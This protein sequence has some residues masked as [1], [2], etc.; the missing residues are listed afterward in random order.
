MTL[1]L[2]GGETRTVQVTAENYDVVQMVQFSDINI[3][4]DNQLVMRSEGEGSL[5]YQVVGSYY[6]PW[7]KLAEYPDLIPGG[8]LMSIDVAYDRTEL[9][10]NDSV[11]VTVTIT[12]QE[13]QADAAMIDLGV[14][15][16]FSVQTEDLE[17]LIAHFSDVVPDYEFPV[18]QRYELTGRQVLVY[19]TNLEAGKPL[20]FTYR[21][22]ARFPLRA[23][24]PATNAYDYY[25]PDVNG[26]NPPQTLTVNP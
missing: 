24:T 17:A 1:Q 12:L 10:V 9:A 14:P 16:G 20:T 5:M 18:I 2:N 15:P 26:E 6:L 3:G 21:L 19:L 22:R 7:D 13:G 4:R 8:E 11:A 25:N 23:Q